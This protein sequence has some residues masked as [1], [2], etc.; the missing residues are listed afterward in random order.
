MT[1][2]AIAVGATL[3]SF[4]GNLL[5]FFVVGLLAKRNEAKQQ[6][7]VEKLRKGYLEMVQRER[8]RLE[9]YARMEG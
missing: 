7:E 1:L 2:L 9:N 6:A 3:G 5:T 4:L 8:T